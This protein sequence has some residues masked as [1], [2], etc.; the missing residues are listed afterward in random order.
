M[1]RSQDAKIASRLSCRGKT[2]PTKIWK[3]YLNLLFILI[4]L[5]RSPGYVALHSPEIANSPLGPSRAIG[6]WDPK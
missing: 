5:I 4:V 2:Y 6:R 3:T 1:F